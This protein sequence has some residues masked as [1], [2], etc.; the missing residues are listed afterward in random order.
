MDIKNITSTITKA[1]IVIL[2]TVATFL[3]EP[4]VITGTRDEIINWKNA[5]ILISGILSILIYDRLPILKSKK[6]GFYLVALLIC[7]I[8][9]YQVLINKYSVTCFKGKDKYRAIISSSSVKSDSVRKDSLNWANFHQDYPPLEALLEVNRGNSIHIWNASD[10][11]PSY[12]SILFI[13][14]SI[15]ITLTIL[16]AYLSELIQKK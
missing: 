16:L 2:T 15:I 3:I 12:Y 4:P 10:L 14:F 13:Y 6:L 11:Y 9:S 8:T 5:F 1:G 7:L